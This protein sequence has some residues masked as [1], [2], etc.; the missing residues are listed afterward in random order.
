[1]DKTILAIILKIFS[2]VFFVSMDALIKKLSFN[3]STFQIVFFRCLFGLIPVLIMLIITKSKIKTNNINLHLIRALIGLIAM[4]FFFKSFYFLP[5]AD[6]SS[7][8]FSSIM[9]TT[10]LA[11]FIL[12]EKVGL[13]RWLAITFGFIGVLVVFRPTSSV[14]SFYSF[15]PLM[16]AFCLSIAIILLKKLLIYDKPPTCSFYLH[17]FV[18][19]IVFP[20]MLFFW[21]TP[22]F[23]EF[24]LLILMGLCGG[25]AQI[26]ATNS[27]KLSEVNILTP[28]DYSAI[29]WAIT[30]GIIFFQDYPD[31]YVITGSIIVIISTYYIIQRERKIGKNINTLKTNTRH[32]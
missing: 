17:F 15:L 8:S 10:L 20:I 19:I 2:V 4:Y 18:A 11:I 27:Y 28:F 9:I 16:A 1:M 7:I 13:R 6:V 14:F 23:N 29:I 21:T 12:N 30:F 24:Y 26:L 31:K 25:I 3:F 22:T 5:L 32:I